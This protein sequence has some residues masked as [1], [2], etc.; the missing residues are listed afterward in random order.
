MP[1]SQDELRDIKDLPKIFVTT[2]PSLIVDNKKFSRG[3]IQETKTLNLKVL[4]T[5]DLNID[6]KTYKKFI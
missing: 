5:G 2:S 6:S 3:E 1:G 4:Q